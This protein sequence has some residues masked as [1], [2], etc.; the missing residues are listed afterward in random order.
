MAE[1]RES[2]I[3]AFTETPDVYQRNDL[4]D[5]IWAFGPKKSGSNVLLNLTDFQHQNVW[6]NF[7]L[8]EKPTASGDSKREIRTDLENSFLSGYQL[9]TL[10][11]PLCEEPMHGVCLIVEEWKIEEEDESAIS[12]GSLGGEKFFEGSKY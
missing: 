4:I 12:T 5:R 2:L 3:K 11:G 9:A 6:N 10:A 8:V 7:K 1:L